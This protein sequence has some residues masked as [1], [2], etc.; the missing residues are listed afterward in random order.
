MLYT[1]VEGILVTSYMLLNHEQPAIGARYRTFHQKQVAL[2]ISLN[3]L[4]FLC[5]HTFISHATGHT[6][7]F[8]H[9]TRCSAGADGT[10]RAMTIRL[11]MSLRAASKAVAFDSTLETFS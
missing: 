4:Q 10:R 3:H 9:A 5:R 7:A 11:T 6:R 1:V 8:Q 2:R